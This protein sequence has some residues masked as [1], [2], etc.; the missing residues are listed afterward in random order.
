MKNP[1]QIKK[2]KYFFTSLEKSKVRSIIE[3]LSFI[4]DKEFSEEGY[5]RICAIERDIRTIKDQYTQ[6]L[7]NFL[8]QGH[9]IN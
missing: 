6:R 8:K 1:N 5:K 4:K 3:D 7:I 2:E 9:M